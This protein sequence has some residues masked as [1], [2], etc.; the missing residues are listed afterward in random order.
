MTSRPGGAPFINSLPQSVIDRYEAQQRTAVK[1]VPAYDDAD[2]HGTREQW[3]PGDRAHF[4]YH[5]LES[6]ESTDAEAW[7]R[8]HRPVTVLAPGE[9]DG[10]EGGY[11]DSTRVERAEDGVPRTYRVRWDDGHEHD[12]FEDELLV[13]PRHFQR[14]DP[15]QQSTAP[16]GS[17]T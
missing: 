4:E 11:A 17:A 3:Q 2:E 13:H 10:W 1:G 5:C 12:V 7:Y 9:G 14:P 15:P 16:K 8:S 6:P